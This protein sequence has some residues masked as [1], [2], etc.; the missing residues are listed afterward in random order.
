MTTAES[1]SGTGK[2]VPD[3]ARVVIIGGGVIGSSVAYHLAKLGW[4]DV[5]LLERDRL[6]SGTTWHAAGLVVSGGMTTETLA[7]MAKYSRDLFEVLEDETGLSTGFRP[8]GY[9]QTASNK[10]RTH[11]LRREADFMGL[12]GID[13]AEIS[14]AEV[15]ALWPQIDTSDVIAGF[16]TANEGR[17]DP[18][19]VSMSLAK[20]ARLAGVRVLEGAQVLGIT[21]EN[22][23]VTGV[24]TES[25]AIEAEYVV[26]CAG[27]W[28]KQVGAMA[29]VSV[30]LQAIEHAYLISEPFEGVSPDLPIFEDPDRFAYYREETGGL[31]VGLFEPV[32]APWSLD[33]IPDNFSFGEIPSDWDRLGPFLEN[34][35][36]ILPALENVG[37]RKLFTGPE[38]FTPDNGFLMGEAPELANFFVAAGFN[39]LGILT[40][41]G[42]GS[43]IA[44]WIV[45]GV[46]PIDVTDVD[47][48]RLNPFQT[49]RPYLAERSV[50]LLGR[51]HSTGSWPHSHPTTARNVRRSVLHERLEKAGAHFGESSGW[52]NTSWFAPPDADIEF[53]LTYARQDWFE[54]HAAEHRSVRNAVALFDMSSMSK[55][56]VQGPDAETTLNRIAANNVAVPVGRCVYTQWLNEQGCVEAD[57]TV[58]RLAED[59]FLVVAAEFFHRRVESMLRRGTRENARVYITDVTSS[60]TLFSVQGP[61]SRELLTKITTANLENDAFPYFT[62]REIDLHH[63]VGY[64]ARMSFV[65]ELGWELFVPTEF[66]L[67]VYDRMIDVGSE[68]GFAHAGM[69]TLESTRTEAGRLDYGLDM[70]N[71]D[72][73]LEAGLSF[74]I[75]FDKPDGFVGRE[76]LVKQRDNRPLKSRLVQFLL[77]DPEPLLYGEEPILDDGRPVGYLRSGA[78]GHT[79]GGAMGFGY[80]EHPEGVTADMVKSGNFEIQVAGERF[81]AKASLRSMYDPKNLRVRI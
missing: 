28:A 3:R 51:L 12:M 56:F 33:K 46:A 7:W 30:P 44:N 59:R 41:G 20:G 52:E 27:M 31:M 45:D 19:N 78:Y 57:V 58:T 71:T 75:D 68:V 35:M 67:G 62:A 61:N 60:Y 10:E 13:R 23:R 70:E 55:F 39:S 49:N 1:A 24:V 37:I 15:A 64:A 29:G 38:S 8:V 4:T 21:Q 11:K 77:E 79:L 48:A 42:A 80:V 18:A 26:N 76:A 47:I 53:K 2:G 66:A 22:G 25:G 63:G 65:G 36:E 17:A 34:A 9:L 16:F 32:A 40:G 73:P 14:A 72:T 5:V 81:P 54:F 50:E 6:T 43:I 74:A 69:E